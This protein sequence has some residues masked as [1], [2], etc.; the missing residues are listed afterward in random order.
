MVG[1]SIQNY[2]KTK[3]V[4]SSLPLCYSFCCSACMW[5]LRSRCAL[6]VAVEQAMVTPPVTEMEITL[7]YD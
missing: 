3:G 4:V 2:N 5:S 6:R 7:G 1:L